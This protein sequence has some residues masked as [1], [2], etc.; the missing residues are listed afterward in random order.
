MN[1]F[2]RFLS[3]LKVDR[4]DIAGIY[5]YALF[6]G[7]INLSLPLGIQAIVNLIVA[8]QISTS[9][10]I[11]VAFVIGGILFTGVLQIL[12]RTISENLQQKIFTR[13]A[14]EFAYR[15]PRIKLESIREQYAPELVNRFF[16]TL[17]IQKGLPKIIIDFSTSSLQVLFGLILL[18]LYH[19][20]FILFS[21]MLLIILYLIFRFT[22]PHGM[23]TGL[24]ESKNKYAVVHW[25]EEVARAMNTFKLSGKSELPLNRTDDLVSDYLK[26]R[27]A[28]FRVL[29]FQYINLVG[30]KVLMA[31]GLLI[32][33]SLLVFDQQMNIGQFVAA[34]III[35]MIIS[36][37]EKL[38]FS[39][40]SVYDTLIAVEKIASVTDLPLEKNEGS[41][42]FYESDGLEVNMDNLSYHTDSI[43]ASQIADFCLKVESGEKVCISGVSGSGKSLLLQTI[44]GLFSQFSG[45]LAFDGVPIQDWDKEELRLMVGNC[46]NLDDIFLGTIED[47]L[48]LGLEIKDKLFYQQVLE[49]TGISS[50]IAEL[51]DGLSTQLLPEGKD[52]PKTLRSR[53]MIARAMIHKPRLLL[54]E[55]LLDNLQHSD[56]ERILNFIKEQ[57]W[58]VIILSNRIGLA[59]KFTKVLWVENGKIAHTIPGSELAQSSLS[60]ALNP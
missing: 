45:K 39:I 52:L 34:E 13:S 49:V 48:T 51:P 42:S 44:A 31:T 14:F 33:G 8:N 10:M 16:D 23:K 38:I 26:S 4:Q 47:N 2:Q 59:S 12:Q 5:L 41:K 3:M 24:K 40:E 58:T 27:K 20:F 28:H 30:F 36:S 56:A 32:I 9:W 6:N 7:L 50:M 60:N 53:F 19:P 43:A 17:S 57:S 35:I 1:S 37:I 21:L 18:S 22:V 15:L 46:L 54:L 11:L 29:V 55:N 25:L